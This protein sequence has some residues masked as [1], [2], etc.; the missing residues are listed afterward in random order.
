MGGREEVE[1]RKSRWKGKGGGERWR[2]RYSVCGGRGGGKV[3]G[4]EKV[5]GEVERTWR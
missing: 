5:E 3:G 1:M 4:K 2:R